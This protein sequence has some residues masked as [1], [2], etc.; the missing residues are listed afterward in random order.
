[1]KD[2]EETMS[3]K[4]VKDKIG[5]ESEE[6]PY[7]NGEDIGDCSNVREIKQEVIENEVSTL[8]FNR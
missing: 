4:P 6:N 2:N 3:L 1:M 7:H 8:T 5:T